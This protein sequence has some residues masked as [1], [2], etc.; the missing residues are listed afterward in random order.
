MIEL[1]TIDQ[2]GQP[3]KYVSAP[4][5]IGPDETHMFRP[6]WPQLSDGVGQITLHVPPGRITASALSIP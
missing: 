4:T 2:K 6:D 1:Q 5:E 3:Q